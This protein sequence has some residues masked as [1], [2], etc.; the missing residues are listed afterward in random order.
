MKN[1]IFLMCIG[2][3]MAGC[4]TGE[5]VDST[6]QA[7]ATESDTG[8]SAIFP[9][10]IQQT[11]L[12]NGLNVVT[13]PFGSPGIA[14]FN[15]VVRVGSREEVEAGK[16]GFA[17][18][19]EHMMFRGTD[20]YP[21]DKYGRV[22]K[23]M[24]AAA[25][26]NTWLDRTIYH[27]TGSAEM[28]DQMFEVEADRFMHLNYSV[29]DFK[30]EAGAVKGEYTKN[31][32][33]QFRQIDEAI[34]NTA[35]TAHTYKHTTMGFF[36]DIVEMPNQYDYS[37]EFYER[38]YRPEYTTIIVVGDVTQEKVNELAEKY[39]GM[40][41]RGSYK[42]DIPVEPPQTETRYTHIQNEGF[43]PFVSL[44][45]KGPAYSDT[46]VDMAALEIIST[47]MFSE[48]SELYKKLIVDEQKAMNLFGYIFF[49]R[50]PYLFQIGALTNDEENLPYIKQTIV[51]ALDSLKQVPVEEQLLE[52]TKS[53]I[54]YNFAMGLDNPDDIS[55]AINYFT[56]VSG[57]PASINRYY[58]LFDRIT[59]E[60]IRQVA[61]KYFTADRLTLG[62]ISSKEEG[63]IK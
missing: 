8:R 54:R 41:E 42:A 62:T 57:D 16:T 38:F 25:N 35:F 4:S 20:T 46:E 55:D 48:S 12:E 2:L 3:W 39:F 10:P 63:G 44:N 6:D 58:A 28:L 36:E 29:P 19:F 43:I 37:L 11:Q 1:L 32:A 50:D 13:V 7:A 26:A 18:F 47:M 60:D 40:W 56:W 51:E 14:T 5:N 17:H 9:Y 22:L 30:V 53:H 59:P 24:G 52:N 23:A 33:N 31:F 45:Y 61:Q 21:K 34:N 27:M 15:I 49:T